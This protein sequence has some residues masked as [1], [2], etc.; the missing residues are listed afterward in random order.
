MEFPKMPL[1]RNAAGGERF[2]HRT[3]TN[4]TNNRN[5]NNRVPPATT[6]ATATTATSNHKGKSNRSHAWKER[7][8]SPELKLR[9]ASTALLTAKVFP[10]PG[11][12]V[13]RTPLGTRNSNG[14]TSVT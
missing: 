5:N 11:G 12:P 13:S 4:N 8:P 3:T 7:S 9:T 6:T 14:L 1:G 2:D 10:T